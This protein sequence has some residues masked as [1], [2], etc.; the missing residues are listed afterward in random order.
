MT[1]KT[2]A[3]CREACCADKKCKSFD[4]GTH[5][6]NGKECFISHVNAD[7]KPDSLIHIETDCWANPLSYN[8]IGNKII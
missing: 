5:G 4:Y 2:W 3:E 8:E 1:D 6:V 7:E